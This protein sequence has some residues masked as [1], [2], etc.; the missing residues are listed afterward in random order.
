[1][2]GNGH[3]DFLPRAQRDTEIFDVDIEGGGDQ[4]APDVVE[5]TLDEAQT[6]FEGLGE[7][8]VNTKKQRK[9]TPK[10]VPRNRWTMDEEA[11]IRQLF[12]RH[13]DAKV[14]PKPEAC[15]KAIR[16]SRKG[17]GLLQHRKKDVQKKKVFRMI[18]VLKK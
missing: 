9:S 12:K 11:E 14:R 4:F 15:L 16:R 1:M 8:E 2:F 6:F 5:E 7:N 13:F 3:N 17:N 10:G 18:D